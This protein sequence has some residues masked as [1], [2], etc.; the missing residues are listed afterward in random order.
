MRTR[1]SIWQPF[2]HTQRLVFFTL[3]VVAS[4]TFSHRARPS[5]LA[6]ILALAGIAV[7][8]WHGAFDGVLARPILR[9]RF[10]RRWSAV[11][12]G[13]YLVL[14]ATVAAL[15]WLTPSLALP[16]FLLYSA[17]HFGTEA[18]EGQLSFFPA[19]QAFAVGFLPIAASCCWHP[20][21]VG[22]IF[23][24]MLRNSVPLVATLNKIGGAALLP[25][26][27]FLAVCTFFK[28]QPI[29]TGVLLAVELVLFWKA[30]PLIAFAVF[31]CCWHTPEH[32]AAS[33]TAPSGR[34][35]FHTMGL[36]LRSGLAPWLVSLVGFGLLV[37]TGF[38]HLAAVAS[39]MF[40]LLSALTVPHMLLNE[41]RRRTGSVIY[42]APGAFHAR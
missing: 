21:Q 33:C 40:I 28:K 6:L 25:L 12:V 35:S 5:T 9:P 24:L 38:H 14:V 8:I 37:A 1:D 27:V 32:L 4:A 13:G 18:Y 19:L 39:S 16:L 34:L 7:A 30:D 15:W 31:F 36:Q 42:P 2:S 20:E 3:C 26:V 17:W 11:F 41:L 22:A 23:A 10:G 29:Q